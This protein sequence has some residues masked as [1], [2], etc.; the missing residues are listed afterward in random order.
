MS[1]FSEGSEIE[2]DGIP[3]PCLMARGLAGS[4]MSQYHLYH[5]GKD[6]DMDKQDKSKPPYKVT[7]W[8]ETERADRS[9]YTAIDLFAGGGLSATGLEMAGFSVLFANEFVPSAQDC[10]LANHKRTVMDCRDIKLVSVSNVLDAIGLKVGELDLLSGSPPCQSFSTAGLREK[11][12]GKGKTYSENGVTQCN[13]TLFDEYVRLLAGLQPMVFVAENVKGLTIGAA[14]GMMG[15][16]EMDLFGAHEDTIVHKLMGAG[17]V[18]RWRV[19][20]AMNYGVPQSRNRVFFVGVRRDLAHLVDVDGFWPRPFA[21]V[22]TVR[23]AL[24]ELYAA[25][26]DQ[27]G[28]GKRGTLPKDIVIEQNSGDFAQHGDVTDRPAPALVSSRNSFDVVE[29]RPG[30]VIVGNKD[31]E[32]VFGAPDVPSTTLMASGA[33]T[34]GEIVDAGGRR[35]FTIAEVKRLSA[36]PDDYQLVGSYAKQWAV[37][38]NGVPPLMAMALGAAIRDNLLAKVRPVDWKLDARPPGRALHRTVK[39]AKAAKPTKAR[40]EAKPKIVAP[41]EAQTAAANQTPTKAERAEAERTH[42]LAED[43][44]PRWRD[45]WAKRLGGR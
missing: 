38:G 10:Y 32:P 17:Y 16:H 33:R 35:K 36:V 4:H 8:A 3:L 43:M 9:G 2:L 5:D 39:K 22:Y 24:P 21:Y 20:N 25:F 13:E 12:W 29:P 27:V 40:K 14:K 28:H 37:C 41:I 42:R 15:G 45:Y 44:Q 34:S 7:P 1:G 11:G 19:L 26:N 6:D 30:D 18:V 31:F 23:D